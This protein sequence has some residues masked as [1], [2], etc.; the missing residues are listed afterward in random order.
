[1]LSVLPNFNPKFPQSLPALLIVVIAHTGVAEKTKGLNLRKCYP[2]H[3]VEE[4]EY[5]ESTYAIGDE[6]DD[7]RIDLIV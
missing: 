6:P 4:E 5:F 3:E 1:M 2:V 7:T